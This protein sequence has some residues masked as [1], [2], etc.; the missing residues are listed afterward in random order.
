MQIS[1][2]GMGSGVDNSSGNVTGAL[3]RVAN[4]MA[5]PS[6]VSDGPDSHYND[7]VLTSTQ[8]VDIVIRGASEGGS[9]QAV[10]STAAETTAGHDDCGIL[11]AILCCPCY[12]MCGS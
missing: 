1:E 4:A 8:G 12:I 9:G 3:T 2:K 10:Q 7:N 6:E 5:F 11:K